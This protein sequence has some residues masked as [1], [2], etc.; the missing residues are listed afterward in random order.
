MIILRGN[1]LSVESAATSQRARFLLRQAV[2]LLLLG[3]IARS[4]AGLTSY[5]TRSLT[6]ATSDPFVRLQLRHSP[7]RP[8]SQLQTFC[9][10]YSEECESTPFHSRVCLQKDRLNYQ[11]VVMLQ[12]NRN[13]LQVTVTLETEKNYFK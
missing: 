1:R 13:N 2:L 3:G 11:C 9:R 8:S 4:A 7:R 6:H 12:V 10:H 5:G